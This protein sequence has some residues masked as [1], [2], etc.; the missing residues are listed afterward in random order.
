MI[1]ARAQTNTHGSQDQETWAEARGAQAQMERLRDCKY[2]AFQGTCKV[3]CKVQPSATDDPSSC[4]FFWEVRYFLKC[5]R[6][7]QQNEYHLVRRTKKDLVAHGIPHEQLDHHIWTSRISQ[8]MA[9]SQKQKR[10]AA[11][12][13]AQS[14]SGS[15]M[16]V[17]ATGSMAQVQ[18]E[19]GS[20]T[21]AAGEGT[22][23]QQLVSGELAISTR[24]LILMITLSVKCPRDPDRQTKAQQVLISL[25]EWCIPVI[26]QD[27]KVLVQQIVRPQEQEESQHEMIHS[28]VIE[29][30]RIV[31]NK[32]METQLFDKITQL[33]EL[34]ITKKEDCGAMAPGVHNTHTAY[35]LHSN[36]ESMN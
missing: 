9:M 29:A 33:I 12:M 5:L 3:E 1:Q 19:P 7:S 35:K 34:A 20:M 11:H 6:N 16:D 14:D 36:K 26:N 21:D 2:F 17:D 32:A 30:M 25:L 10:A 18:E 22:K 27:L 23:A 13:A 4:N 28:H 8:T 15:S 24:A 31:R